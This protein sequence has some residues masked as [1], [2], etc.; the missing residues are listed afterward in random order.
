M[1]KWNLK[2]R[3]DTV[4]DSKRLFVVAEIVVVVIVII[5]NDV[6]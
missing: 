5:P 2:T 3:K 4:K 1:N 6:L